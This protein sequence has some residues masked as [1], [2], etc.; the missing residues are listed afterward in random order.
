[1]KSTTMT[2]AAALLAATT[3]GAGAWAAD[4]KPLYKDCGHPTTTM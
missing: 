4:G 3:A 1:M 2:A